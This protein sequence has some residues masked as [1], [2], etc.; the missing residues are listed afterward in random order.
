MRVAPSVGAVGGA[1]SKAGVLD[2]EARGRRSSPAR[3]TSSPVAS[4]A[5]LSPSSCRTPPLPSSA[6]AF[7]SAALGSVRCCMEIAGRRGDA[8]VAVAKR[9]AGRAVRAPHVQALVAA[10]AIRKARLAIVSSTWACKRRVGDRSEVRA[11]SSSSQAW[12]VDSS[13]LGILGRVPHP[14]HPSYMFRPIHRHGFTFLPCVWEATRE[15]VGGRGEEG[16]LR[17][18]CWPGD[19]S[20]A[21]GEAGAVRVGAI[22]LLF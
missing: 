10:T 19:T 3:R 22:L 5:P 2:A 4:F 13:A 14:T 17:M 8:L 16:A 18:D 12:L 1:R 7:V 9:S 21:R 15:H 6:S 11:A 20:D